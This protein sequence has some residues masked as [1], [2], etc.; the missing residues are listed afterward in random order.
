MALNIAVYLGGSQLSRWGANVGPLTLSGEYW[1]LV[2]AAFVHAGFLHIAFNMWCLYSL[3][4][5]SERLFGKI[6]TV[7]LYLLT[8]VG[9]AILSLAYDH[10]RSEVGA[11][12]AIFGLAG[13]ILIGVKFGDLAMPSGEK[14]ALFGS[15][16]FFIG[17]NF[18]L[19]MG[20]NVD[21]MCHLGGFVSGLIIGLPMASSFSSSKAGEFIRISVLTG[22]A[23]LLLLAGHELVRLHGH[24][25]RLFVATRYAN[26]GD[27]P[28]A[29][30]ILE[31][32]TTSGQTSSET[33]ALL[34]QI[35]EVTLQRDKAAMA[36]ER[37]LAL[38][39]SDEEA[40]DGLQR[41]RGDVP[42]TK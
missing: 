37:A 42:Q 11:S 2:T 10:T 6:A 31:R 12:G 9:G 20:G 17:I 23:L 25:S 28:S 32:D 38:N 41:M 27:F 14:R 30:A 39:P 36:Y 4:R 15:L 24:E 21:N 34:G 26:A 35:Y 13:A 33:Y 7:L 18:F 16:V 29:T 5:V 19:G 1:R 40:K 8:G 3:G 22:A